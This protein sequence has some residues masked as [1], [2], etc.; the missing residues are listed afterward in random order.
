MACQLAMPYKRLKMRQVYQNALLSRGIAL[1]NTM[2]FRLALEEAKALN[3]GPFLSQRN[4]HICALRKAPDRPTQ[5]WRSES[6]LAAGRLRKGASLTFDNFSCR[7]ARHFRDTG[8]RP[9]REGAYLKSAL[10]LCFSGS[11]QACPF[12][13][14]VGVLIASAIGVVVQLPPADK[15]QLRL[16]PCQRVNLLYPSNK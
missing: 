13:Q 5:P 12:P 15:L 9:A 6:L 4:A 8:Q 16:Y 7:Q 1:R 11:F 2:A 3:R 14:F 10:Y